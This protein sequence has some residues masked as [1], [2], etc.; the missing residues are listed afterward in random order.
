MRST[1]R[2]HGS[3]GQGSPRFGRVLTAM[4]TPFASDGSLHLDAAQQLARHLVDNG[5]D[6]VVVAGTTGESATLTHGEQASLIEAVRAAIPD[7]CLVAGAGSN[8]TA[9]A[10][11]LTEKATAAGADGILQVT[12][13]YNRPSQAGIEAHFRAVAAATDLPVVVY[14]IPI[15][16]GRKISDEVLLSL[17]E[18][19]NIVG[20]KDAAANP[21]ATAALMAKAPAGTDLYSGDDSLTLP[22]LSVG[23][24]GV[25]G[26]ATHW[27]GT[28]M[29]EMI[30][31][32]EKGDV[33]AATR[34]NARL[35]PSYDYETGDLAPN[36]IPSKVMMNLLDIPVGHCRPPMGPIPANLPD[37][38]RAVLAGLDRAL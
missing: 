7:H 20:I 14:D 24:C 10:I 17:L 33:A 27:A 34:L 15:R 30:L 11:D 36:P 37:D 5:N 31:A 38:A 1:A 29:L 9:A 32:Y 3:G 4:V 22:F 6:G 2:L 26:V 16:T 12:P 28:E 19:D 25:I 35:I 13:Y 8:D 18:V 23:G 21:S